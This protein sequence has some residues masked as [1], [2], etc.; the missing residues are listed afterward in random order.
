M[1]Q[2]CLNVS[3]RRI[4]VTI[5]AGEAWS[6]LTTSPQYADVLFICFCSRTG[7]MINFDGSGDEL[8]LLVTGMTS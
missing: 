2:D 4:L 3:A 1:R 6:R 8:M 5:W 7:A